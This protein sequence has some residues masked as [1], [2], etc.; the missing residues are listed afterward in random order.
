MTQDQLDQAAEAFCATVATSSRIHS[1]IHVGGEVFSAVTP[2]LRRAFMAGAAMASAL[3]QAAAETEAPH[4]PQA[5]T[6]WRGVEDAEDLK[7]GDYV[8][9]FARIRGSVIFGT[10]YW[11]TADGG[12]GWN[13]SAFLSWPKDDFRGS[14]EPTHVATMLAPPAAVAGEPVAAPHDQGQL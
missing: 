14:F 7:T 10:A 8:L 9:A 4:Q 13:A 2:A 12:P 11:C 1:E 5:L 3:R 6:R